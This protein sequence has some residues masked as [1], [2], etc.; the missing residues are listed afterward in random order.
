MLWLVPACV[1]YALVIEAC[2]LMP[3]FCGQ[4]A[5]NDR[6]RSAE[7]TL[8]NLQAQ[9]NISEKT[10]QR[11]TLE[12]DNLTREN[13]RLD[14]ETREVNTLE[15]QC[16]WCDGFGFFK[17][18]IEIAI[19][20]RIGWWSFLFVSV[21][22]SSHWKK[23]IWRWLLLRASG[24]S[25]TDDQAMILNISE[26][27]DF[28]YNHWWNTVGK[29]LSLVLHRCVRRGTVSRQEFMNWRHYLSRLWKRRRHYSVSVTVCRLNYYRK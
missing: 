24:R 18:L 1:K 9:L 19:K 11:L 14:V 2:I 6:R 25:R 21:L 10:I 28:D 20:N 12:R 22:L 17:Y 4:A 5:S 27:N 7:G 23:N 26:T 13:S 3:V 16:T 8:T 15:K 29:I